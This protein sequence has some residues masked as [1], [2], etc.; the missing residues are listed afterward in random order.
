MK[1]IPSTQKI[2]NE[3]KSGKCGTG[4]SLAAKK[5]KSTSARERDPVPAAV[6]FQSVSRADSDIHSATIKVSDS[7]LSKSS[8]TCY[9]LWDLLKDLALRIFSHIEGLNEEQ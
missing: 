2:K 4:F 1:G 7:R 5:K 3:R 8:L 6:A 9:V